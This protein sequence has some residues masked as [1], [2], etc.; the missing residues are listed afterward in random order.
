MPTEAEFNELKSNCTYTWATLNG[1]RGYK[2]TSKKNGNSIFIPAAGYLDAGNLED[3][4]SG[5]CY[6]SSSLDPDDPYSTRCLDF[7]SSGFHVGGSNRCLGFPI[8]P[9]ME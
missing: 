9:V 7:Y 6:W 3:A 1:K 2:I 5:G 8:R 4:G